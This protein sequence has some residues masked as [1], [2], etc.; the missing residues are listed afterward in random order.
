MVIKIYGDQMKPR[1]TER[2][3]RK[4]GA[5]F[6]PSPSCWTIW[7]INGAGCGVQFAHKLTSLSLRKFS[8]H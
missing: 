6:D 3:E 2:S 7:V 1:L 5:E 8:A 4:S